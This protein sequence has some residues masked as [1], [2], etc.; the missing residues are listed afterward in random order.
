MKVLVGMS[1]GIDSSVTAWLLKEKGYDVEGVTMTLWRPSSPYP[2]P[3][4]SSSCYCQDKSEDL[5]RISKIAETIGIKHTVIDC[6]EV[7]EREVLDNFCS[8]YVSGRTPNPCIWCNS[9]VKF[10]ALIDYAST[11]IDFDLF[12]TGHYA[13]IVH[14]E[15]SGRYELRKGLDI[16]KDQSYFLSRLDQKQLSRTLFPLGDYTKTEIREIDERLGFHEKGAGESQDFYGSDYSELLQLD[17]KSGDIVLSDGTVVGRHNGYWHYTIGQRKGLGIA[18]HEPLYV[19]EIDARNNR[20]VVATADESTFSLLSAKY[21]VFVSE[22]GFDSRIY[23][24]KIRSMD[25]GTDAMVSG[26]SS[27]FS[28]RFLSPVRGVAPGQSAVVYDGDRVIASGFIA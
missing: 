5:D 23:K 1:G 6:A 3:I 12:A 11:F 2:A 21:P 16:K 18:Y 14:N 22:E 26:N 17:D 15:E 13:R 7:F 10:G 19:T 8:E 9:R 28:V 24:V 25:K 27:G 20:V 4:S